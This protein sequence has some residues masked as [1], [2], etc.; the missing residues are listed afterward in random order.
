MTLAV[1][2]AAARAEGLALMGAFHTAPGDRT[3]P[4][5]RTLVLLGPDDR[6]FWERFRASPE[7]SDCQPD[8]I[9]RWSERVIGGLAN[10]LDAL[11]LF[12]FTGP[13][14]HPFTSWALRS[15]RAWTS[16][17][18]LMVHDHQGLFASFRGALALA[19]RLELE[20]AEASG[21]CETCE[22]P[23]RTAC[24]AGALGFDGYDTA[25]CHR[26]LDTSVGSDCLS[27]GC[28]VRRVCPVGRAARVDAQSAFH[29]A[30]FH[31]TQKE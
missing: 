29:M 27:R 7:Q 13:P 26:F 19:T 24:P 14:W 31:V 23:C 9:D 25:T 12:P 1:I 6:V 28:A 22:A 30:A 21:P 16:P 20:G 17:V 15:G 10:R 18:M 3:P 5:T 4:A 2:E 11:P 8:P